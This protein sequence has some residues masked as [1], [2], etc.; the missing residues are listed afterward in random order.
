VPGTDRPAGTPRRRRPDRG[1]DRGSF[2]VIAAILAAAMIVMLAFVV[3]A[4]GRITAYRKA[5]NVAEQAARAASNAVNAA[6]A[7]DNTYRPDPAA[8]RSAA[9]A[10]L[11]TAD[12]S[13]TVSVSD[14]SVHVTVTV[15]YQSRLGGLTGDGPVRA[16]ADA[17]LLSGPNI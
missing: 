6:A 5:H 8:A 16:T 3:D 17:R 11:A 13:G 15:P 2:T 7:R 12:S 9:Q 14:T 1:D 10:Y 4:G